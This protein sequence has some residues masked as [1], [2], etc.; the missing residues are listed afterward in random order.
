MGEAV[1][2][3]ILM[4]RKDFREAVNVVKAV[5]RG[6]Y[7]LPELRLIT[8]GTEKLT[9][10]QDMYI[11]EDPAVLGVTFGDHEA[12]QFDI[13]LTPSITDWTTG[14]AMDTV[15]H[16]LCHGYF[17][18]YKHGAQFRRYLGRVLFH[19]QAQVRYIDAYNLVSK[20]VARY[21]RSSTEH[22]AMEVDFLYKAFLQEHTHVS[23]RFEELQNAEAL[24]SV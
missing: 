14:F 11:H 7:K 22:Q 12:N 19:Y 1:E 17:G 23:R 9:V 21:S 24:V 2:Y 6:N 15:L 3:D 8:D 4:P 16:E 20:M 10:E 5:R 13:W 18:C